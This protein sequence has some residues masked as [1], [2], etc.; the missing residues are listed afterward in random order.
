MCN[1]NF[2]GRKSRSDVETLENDTPFESPQPST[3]SGRSLRSRLIETPSTSQS[4][5]SST[6]SHGKFDG[7]TPPETGRAKKEEDKKEEEEEE[8]EDEDD[9]DSS[10]EDGG[11]RVSEVPYR[12]MCKAEIK[13][14]GLR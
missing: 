12:I 7:C 1:C 11:H 14:K 9:E 8:G 3:S 13:K 10:Q 4:D 5:D 6:L 2:R